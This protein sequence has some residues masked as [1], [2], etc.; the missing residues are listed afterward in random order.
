MCRYTFKHF[1]YNMYLKITYIL[2]DISDR[3]LKNIYVRYS[4]IT[5]FIDDL[6]KLK[7]KTVAGAGIA[8]HACITD[9]FFYYH[10]MFSQ[11][12]LCML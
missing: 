9:R 12:N 5:C 3:V 10:V 8:E 2:L 6:N 7:S 4:T 1:I 11:N